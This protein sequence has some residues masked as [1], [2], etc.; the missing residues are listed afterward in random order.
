M[1]FLL[2][3]P[4]KPL[5]QPFKPQHALYV[6]SLLVQYVL[7]MQPISEAQRFLRLNLCGLSPLILNPLPLLL[8]HNMAQILH[9]HF[10]II[11]I[12]FNILHKLSRYQFLL[13]IIQVPPLQQLPSSCKSLAISNF[14]KAFLNLLFLQLFILAL[15]DFLKHVLQHHDCDDF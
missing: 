3:Q 12:L 1:P 11:L 6:L 7:E 15:F 13:F 2:P 8:H 14:A 10:D 4:F 5:Q 9:L